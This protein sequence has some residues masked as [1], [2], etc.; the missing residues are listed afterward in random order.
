[1]VQPTTDAICHISSSIVELERKN[2]KVSL[3]KRE[4]TKVSCRVV[5]QTLI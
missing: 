4:Q 5:F 2:S 1:M 3:K